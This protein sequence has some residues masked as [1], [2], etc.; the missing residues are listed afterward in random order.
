MIAVGL[1]LVATL[2]QT[3]FSSIVMKPSY[4]LFECPWIFV[5]ALFMFLANHVLALAQV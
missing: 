1:L 2:H 5:L 3:A 4:Q